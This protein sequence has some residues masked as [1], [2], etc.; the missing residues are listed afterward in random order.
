MSRTNT[1][2]YSGSWRQHF[3]LE[4]DDGQYVPLIA[5]DPR[6][7]PTRAQVFKLDSTWKAKGRSLKVELNNFTPVS[8]PSRPSISTNPSARPYVP[9]DTL[10]P[11][12]MAP[13]YSDIGN[14][15]LC[16]EPLAL[17]RALHP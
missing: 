5:S 12:K 13:A 14:D 16:R 10:T 3:L 9:Q 6:A 7:D 17:V 8:S 1:E 11:T 2:V 15:L 4:T